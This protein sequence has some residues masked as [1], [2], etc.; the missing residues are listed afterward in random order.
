MAHPDARPSETMAS[1][2]SNCMAVLL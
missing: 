1:T 2:M